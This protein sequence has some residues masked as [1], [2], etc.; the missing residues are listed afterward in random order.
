M[1]TLHSTI[2][3]NPAKSKWWIPPSCVSKELLKLHH[4]LSGGKT[5]CPGKKRLKLFHHIYRI[6]ILSLSLAKFHQPFPE[7]VGDFLGSQLLKRCEVAIIW[8][9]W[10]STVAHHHRFQQTVLCK[11]APDL[12]W[13]LGQKGKKRMAPCFF[14]WFLTC[15]EVE[16]KTKAY[17]PEI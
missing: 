13:S 5:G 8:L 9:D 16:Y 10:L 15:L 3:F 1:N 7:I 2:H 14:K 17:N 4:S 6:T 12:C 11:K